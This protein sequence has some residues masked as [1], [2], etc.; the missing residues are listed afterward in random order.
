MPWMFLG[1]SLIPGGKS[2]L[3]SSLGVRLPHACLPA[4]LSFLPPGGLLPQKSGRPLSLKGTIFLHLSSSSCICY[5]LT[6]VMKPS[7]SNDSSI[8][9]LTL[10][11]TGS[12]LCP[13]PEVYHIPSPFSFSSPTFSSLPVRQTESCL[14]IPILPLF[15]GS[16]QPV[17]LQDKD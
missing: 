10:L 1:Y 9:S 12:Y 16:S 15:H 7:F 14:P 6:T 8:A 3:N 17:T 13:I 11:V 5:I 2:L 4:F